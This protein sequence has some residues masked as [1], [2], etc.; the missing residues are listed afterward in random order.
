ML[1]VNHYWAGDNSQPPYD[2]EN[3]TLPSGSHIR[4]QDVGSSSLTLPQTRHIAN[5]SMHALEQYT[6][7]Y[8]YNP[9][10]LSPALSAVRDSHSPIR[11]HSDLGSPDDDQ[12]M[13]LPSFPLRSFGSQ[14]MQLPPINESTGRNLPMTTIGSHD[15]PRTLGQSAT[16]VHRLSLVTTANFGSQPGPIQDSG[17]Y[18][19]TM[20][21]G[22]QSNDASPTESS[23]SLLPLPSP[24]SSDAS[25]T[26]LLEPINTI[27]P[28]SSAPRPA[29]TAGSLRLNGDLPV[30]SK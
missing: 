16:S 22:L 2:D 5:D 15:V 1:D 26:S 25:T 13:S 18:S 23:N 10:S 30:T 3:S 28:G 11:F 9:Y 27:Q 4:T 24:S 21:D 29:K 17:S 6:T 19:N 7:H 14:D 12:S 20:N 8:Q